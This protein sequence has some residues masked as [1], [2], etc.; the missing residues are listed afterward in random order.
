[1]SKPKLKA[2]QTSPKFSA[3]R[4][5]KGKAGYKNYKPA[6]VTTMEEVLALTREHSLSS[7]LYGS[8]VTAGGEKCKGHRAGDSIIENGNLLFLDFEDSGITPPEVQERL[9]GY[10]AFTSPSKSWSETVHKIHGGIQVDREL[11]QD[12]DEFKLWYRAAVQWLGLDKYHDPAMESRTQNLAAHWRDDGPQ[13]FCE[14]ELLNM[15]EVLAAY[16]PPEGETSGRSGSGIAGA[17]P[18]DTIFRTTRELDDLTVKEMRER[19]LDKGKTRV[20]CIKGLRHDGRADTAFVNVSD[21]GTVFYHCCG[22]RCGESL[23]LQTDPADEFDVIEE[24]EGR[25]LSPVQRLAMTRPNEDNVALVAAE[26]FADKYVHLHGT[27]HWHVWDGTRW[28]RDHDGKLRDQLRAMIR[29]VNSLE[30]KVGPTKVGFLGNVLTYMRDDR[31]FARRAEAFDLDTWLLNTPTGTVDLRTGEMHPHSPADCITKMTTVGPSQEDGDRFQQFMD[32]VCDGDQELVRFHQMSLGACLSGAIADHW[33]LFWIGGGRNGKNTLGDLV[34][35]ILGDYARNVPS[36]TLMAKQHAEH[37]TEIMSLKGCRLVT[38]SEVEDGAR[39]NESRINQVT[40]DAM[41]SG[42]FMRQD[43]VEFPRTH[44]HLIY[45]NHRPALKNV[46]VALRSRLKILPFT[47]SFNGREEKGLPETLAAEGGAVLQWLID[48]H[49]AWYENGM[50]LPVCKAVDKEQQAYFAAQGTVET[51]L[52]ERC[53]DVHEERSKN[54]WP[55]STSLYQDYKDWKYLRGERADEMGPWGEKMGQR[56]NRVQS[57]GKRYVGLELIEKYES[58]F[59]DE[60]P[61]KPRELD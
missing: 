33:L 48:G 13:W 55:T 46:T 21:S 6:E 29:R 43:F 40:G 50:K 38:S 18:D 47:V 2:V 14:G 61:F 28:I 51:W 5:A 59:E 58:P 4:T 23:L 7:F 25:E 30:V 19:V 54:K 1:M 11:P 32:E 12:K 15:D 3:S 42:R 24:A 27:G 10:R 35:D 45:G 22:G 34:M 20:H 31:T 53:T 41:L 39:W 26:V 52:S 56:Y 37:K 8:G 36:D 16:L 9:D 17:V 60:L 44:K 57:N 49:V